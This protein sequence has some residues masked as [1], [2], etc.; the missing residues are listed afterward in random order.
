M[1]NVALAL[2]DLG[3]TLIARTPSVAE[4]IFSTLSNCGIRVNPLEIERAYAESELWQ[5]GQILRENAGAPRMDDAEFLEHIVSVYRKALMPDGNA[6][7]AFREAL[8][9][10]GRAY[11]LKDG[12]LETLPR[13]CAR[14]IRV[15]VASNNTPSVR[16]VLDALGI[17][18]YLSCTVIS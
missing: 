16:G 10:S 4:A 1:K 2:F 5:G 15:G 3:N 6:D 12:A 11:V 8:G 18:P 17:S 9:A 14:G 7:G 13:L